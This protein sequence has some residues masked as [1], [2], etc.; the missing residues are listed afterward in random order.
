MPHVRRPTRIT[1]GTTGGDRP[2]VRRRRPLGGERTTPGSGAFLR[3]VPHGLP[4]G[5][6]PRRRIVT[7]PGSLQEAQSPSILTP[8]GRTKKPILTPLSLG[9]SQQKRQKKRVSTS[10]Q[11]TRVP[12][13]PMTVRRAEK[14]IRDNRLRTR[15]R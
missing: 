5:N 13:S 9:K 1:R 6:V 11:G 12:V 3:L 4:G 2:T 14:I 7:P 15:G 8:P 10:L